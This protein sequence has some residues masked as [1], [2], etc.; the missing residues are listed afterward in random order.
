M[1]FRLNV[2]ASVFG[3]VGKDWY[4]DIDIILYKIDYKS[5]SVILNRIVLFH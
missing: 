5:N 4:D 2:N 1:V 3:E